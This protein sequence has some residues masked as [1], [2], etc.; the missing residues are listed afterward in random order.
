MAATQTSALRDWD[1][2]VWAASAPASA[3]RGSGRLS[4]KI[5]ALAAC[6]L[7]TQH[8]MSH[9]R[10]GSSWSS[11]ASS[12]GRLSGGLTEAHSCCVSVL[13]RALVSS[14]P[15]LMLS[16]TTDGSHMLENSGGAPLPC[17]LDHL[18]KFVE[19]VHEMQ[20][21]LASEGSTEQP[22]FKM[23]HEAVK[24]DLLHALW[25]Q[26]TWPSSEGIISSSS[27]LE[28]LHLMQLLTN[29]PQQAV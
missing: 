23:F 12:L 16:C 18:R 7:V 28:S 14:S 20:I 10:A 4:H 13:S 19:C 8:L 3:S 15:S 6:I 17:C 22:F 21:K 9:A 2:A 11:A 26:W 1:L 5:Q 27:Y 24:H 29:F 25:Q